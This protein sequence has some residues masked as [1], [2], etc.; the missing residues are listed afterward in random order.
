MRPTALTVPVWKFWSRIFQWLWKK[1]VGITFGTHRIHVYDIRHVIRLVKVL[2]F[3][4]EPIRDQCVPR[5]THTSSGQLIITLI[6]RLL[7]EIRFGI[8]QGISGPTAGHAKQPRLLQTVS[9]HYA[10][11][12]TELCVQTKVKVTCFLVFFV[13]MI[14]RHPAGSTKSWARL[15]NFAFVRVFFWSAALSSMEF[16]TNTCLDSRSNPENFKGIGQKS[17]SQDRIF[18]RI[19]VQGGV[20]P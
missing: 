20:W 17:K 2:S 19:T 4:S 14:L 18:F 3:C 1:T 12:T 9:T 16:C 6:R 10:Q 7:N 8:V 5:H 15:D 11:A 13:C